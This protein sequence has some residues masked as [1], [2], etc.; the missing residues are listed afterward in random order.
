MAS[1]EI[2]HDGDYTAPVPVGARRF[3]YPFL[4]NGDRVSAVFEEEYWQKFSTY[5]PENQPIPHSEL[6]DFYLI[7]ESIPVEFMAGLVRFTRT[8]ARIPVQQS[9][10]SSLFVT[11]PDISSIGGADSG[12][13]G[14]FTAAVT[15][16][17][18]N[19]PGYVYGGY[20]FAS[21]NAYTRV[22]GSSLVTEASGGTFTLTYKGDTTGSL[23]YN[24]SGATIAAALNALGDVIADGLTF[25]AESGISTSSTATL[26]LT[27]TAGTTT[28]PVTMDA[29]S[30]DPAA[31]RT[32]FT[33]MIHATLQT[34]FIGA[35][36]TLASHG[37]DAGENLLVY[38]ANELAGEGGVTFELLPPS[39]LWSVIDSNTIAFAPIRGAHARTI[40]GQEAFGY[41]PGTVLTRCK[42]VS[43]FYLPGVSVGIATAD[44]IPLPTFQGDAATLLAAI[45]AGSTS[46]NYEVGELTQW[47]D[48]PILMR[49]V[50]TINADQL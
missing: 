46:I 6:R 41:T 49:T 43:D 48:S 20:S 50:T 33:W 29:S 3:E 32:A 13:V 38:G 42:R 26:Q 24:D 25:T 37:F 35:R 28:S 18:D 19:G 14:D 9:V 45:L 39:T 5:F 40:F 47:R 1:N 36:V 8:F 30:L 10:P 12:N 44:D 27:L 7:N 11:K 23:N 34:I 21:P 22:P 17:N 31:S 2:L 16:G 4:K 15:E